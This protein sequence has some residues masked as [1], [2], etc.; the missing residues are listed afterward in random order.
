MLVLV[1]LTKPSALA[2]TVISYLLEWKV[3]EE[4]RRDRLKKLLICIHERRVVSHEKQTAPHPIV[5]QS[6]SSY[7]R[8]LYIHTHTNSR[9]NKKINQDEQ[10]PSERMGLTLVFTHTYEPLIYSGLW[11]ALIITTSPQ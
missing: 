5:I 4:K 1:Y 10:S 11:R 2:S 8:V 9:G 7:T 3:H 6:L